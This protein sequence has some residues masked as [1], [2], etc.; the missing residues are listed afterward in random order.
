M[1]IVVKPDLVIVLVITKTCYKIVIHKHQGLRKKEEN[2]KKEDKCEDYGVTELL[3]TTP[4]RLKE[5][6]LHE[7]PSLAKEQSQR[8]FEMI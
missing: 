6:E 2:R 8:R 7:K 3:E 4:Y 1:S 5:E